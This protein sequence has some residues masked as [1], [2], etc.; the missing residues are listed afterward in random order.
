[1]E[2]FFARID[3][4]ASLN[5][6]AREICSKCNIDNYLSSKIVEIGYEDFNFIIQ[7]KNQK[8]FVKIFH[9]ERTSQDCNNYMDR[10]NLSNNIDI[11][12]PKAICF[13]SIK[14][15]DKDLKFV[16]FEYIQGK[17]FL[18]LEEMPNETEIKE[19]IR[20]MANIHKAEL[21]SDFIYDTWTITNFTKEFEAK[22]KYLDKQYYEEFKELSNKLQKV[23]L[24]KLPHSFVHGDII[25][26]N[27]IKDKNG[28]LW[29]IDFAVSNYLPRIVDLVVT[30]DNLCLD[31][32]SRENTIKNFKLIV[33]EYEKYNKLT[34]YEKQIIPLFYDIGNAMGILQINA[35]KQGG[36]YS[37]EDEFWLK[38]SEQGLKYSDTEFWSEIFEE[39]IEK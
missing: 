3:V 11:N 13:N 27:V 7:S 31:P 25:S 15:E 37:E 12:T 21:K 2:D 9:K 5:E 1:M 4:N 19:I 38:V 26:S 18:D 6:I 36:D 23:D 8:Y 24:S 30:G 16:V 10:I 22:G 32:N 17:S 34:D 29:I 35:L 28:K 20:Q 14:I 39:E 33:S